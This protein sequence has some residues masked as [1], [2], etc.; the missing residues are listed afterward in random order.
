M[1]LRLNDFILTRFD[2]DVREKFEAVPRKS[3]LLSKPSDTQDRHNKC[4]A[5][6]VFSVST[7]SYGP[8]PRFSLFDLWLSG[9]ALRSQID[10]EKTRC[11]TYGAVLQNMSVLGRNLIRL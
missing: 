11:V 7:V 5:N 4:L 9:F 6:L 2:L 10:G 1:F 8:D 3:N